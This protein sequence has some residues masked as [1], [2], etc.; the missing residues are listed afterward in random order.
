MEHNSPDKQPEQELAEL[1]AEEL[2]GVTME[3]GA[4]ADLA[5]ESDLYDFCD[6]E[7]VTLH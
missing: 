4:F 6:G 1:T 5:D 7:P 3:G 2:M